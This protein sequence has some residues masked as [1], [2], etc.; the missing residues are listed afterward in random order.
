MEPEFDL[1]PAIMRDEKR[2][3]AK[4]TALPK[5][6]LTP[7][8]LSEQ[9]GLST[10]TLHRYKRDE[11]IPFFQPGGRGTKVLYPLRAIESALSES[12]QESLVLHERS[13]TAGNGAASKQL[14]GPRPRWQN[15]QSQEPMK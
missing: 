5:L 1:E 11:K 6:Y 8:Q 9:S 3:T 15:H 10:S 12:H 14:P 4:G 2:T 7:K 13:N